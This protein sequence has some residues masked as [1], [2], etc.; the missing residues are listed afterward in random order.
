MI[1]DDPEPSSI[2][3]CYCPACVRLRVL[4]AIELHRR[5]AETKPRKSKRIELSDP[6][7]F[8]PPSFTW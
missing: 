2:A 8:E 5:I 7:L 3:G 4:E 1:D 6:R